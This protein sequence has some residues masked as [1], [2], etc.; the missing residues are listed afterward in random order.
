MILQSIG[1]PDRIEDRELFYRSEGSVELEPKAGAFHLKDCPVRFDT[2]F[3]AFSLRKW[4]KYTRLERVT[5]ALEVKGSVEVS[6]LCHNLEGEDDLH[7]TDKDLPEVNA[8][9]ATVYSQ[10]FQC[11]DYT[12]VA[13]EYP[14][15]CLDALALSFVVSPMS[16]EASIRGIAYQTEADAQPVNLAL[17]ICTYKRE[18]YVIANMEMLRRDV[19]DNPVS[20]LS[21][22]VRVYIADNGQT[23]D[24]SRFE[25]LPVTVY[26]NKNSGGSGGF[27]R[28]AIEA[29]HDEDYSA[30]HV[31]LMDDDISFNVWALE[32]NHSFLSLIKP[33]YAQN[34]IGG[35]MLNGGHRH[36]LYTAGDRFTL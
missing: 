3:N 33:E 9:T 29:I 1:W 5:L 26:P 25:G 4:K 23:L 15:E 31:I 7:P 22:H 24:A 27:S 16:P 21:G 13:L 2:Y 14:E 30:T 34:L 20:P 11:D 12:A 36:W 6:L 35:S 18:D 10:T 19:F 8:L 32:R 17:A 28:A